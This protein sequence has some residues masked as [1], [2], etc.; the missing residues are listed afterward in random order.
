MK[1]ITGAMRQQRQNASRR[2]LAKWRDPEWAERN[3]HAISDGVLRAIKP[4]PR[5]LAQ[6][7][8]R[9]LR[10][11]LTVYVDESTIDGLRSVA[12]RDKVSLAEVI[13][14]FL[15]WGLEAEGADE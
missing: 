3:R 10:R 5:A 14:T 2:M 8:P 6:G 1:V 15:V 12:K 4:L 7:H 9:G 13:R 11:S